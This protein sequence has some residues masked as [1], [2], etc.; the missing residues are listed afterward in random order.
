VFKTSLRDGWLICSARPGFDFR[1]K[2]PPRVYRSLADLV[3]ITHVGFVAF[4]VVGLLVILC[5][6]FAGGRGFGIRGFGRF[7]S[8]GSDW[9]SCRRGSG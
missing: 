4:V 7:I 6:G 1:H 9:S 3:L 5:G 2:C 8:R